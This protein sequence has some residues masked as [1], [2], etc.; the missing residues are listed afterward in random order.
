MSKGKTKEISDEE[1]IELCE[2]G[3]PEEIL[4]AIK[5][6]ANVNAEL[7]D[8]LDTVT[9]MGLCLRR[10]LD[11]LNEG[12]YGE[13]EEELILALLD[14]GFDVN[15]QVEVNGWDY[16]FSGPLLCVIVE[17]IFPLHKSMVKRL[18]DAGADI[19]VEAAPG[20]T[21]LRIFLEHV[22]NDEDEDEDTYADDFIEGVNFLLN[23][24]ADIKSCVKPKKLQWP[25]LLHAAMMDNWYRNPGGV[26]MLSR[27]E[28]LLSLGADV[29]EQEYHD[30]E[31]PLMWAV[32]YRE[33]GYVPMLLE[34]GADV[35]LRD[36]KGRTALM[37]LYAFDYDA[38]CWP[39]CGHPDD[40]HVLEIIDSLIS[41]GADVNAA[42]EDGMTTLMY[43]A[44]KT[45]T[46]EVLT[47]LLGAGANPA[48][49]DKLGLCAFDYA[50]KNK[51]L[52][53][54]IE[55]TLLSFPGMEKNVA[56]DNVT[57]DNKEE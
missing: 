36:I 22:S 45:E 12:W 28:Y 3:T 26:E 23:A 29:N 14:A 5:A 31:T 53:G 8:G 24:G 16:Y 6:G 9:P 10:L 52:R 34:R 13:L 38:Y 50:M 44:E 57:A 4:A 25:S 27:F 49:R 18:L 19:N 55:F 48:A 43:A 15:A 54:T 42:D 11:K 7:T 56:D 30:G 32:Q 21:P 2:D 47:A 1:F 37:Y 20:R 33:I 41:A 46:P 17:S 35:N 51:A 39:N 40:T